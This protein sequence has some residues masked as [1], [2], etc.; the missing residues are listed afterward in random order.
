MTAPRRLADPPPGRQEIHA[1]VTEQLGDLIAVPPSGAISADPAT[2]MAGGQQAADAALRA[3][4]VRGYA[5]LRNNVWPP[6]SRGSSR[7]SPYIRHGLLTLREVWNHVADGPQADVTKFRDELLWQ[8]YA[9]HL[10]A[11]MGTASRKSYRFAVEERTAQDLAEQPGGPWA[12]SALC[13]QS[14]WT[15]LVADGWLTNQTRMWLASHWSVRE[16]LGW[17]DGEDLMYRHLLDG[18]RAARGGLAA[19]VAVVGTAPSGI[20]RLLHGGGQ[21]RRIA[22]GQRQRAAISSVSIGRFINRSER[23]DLQSRYHRGVAVGGSGDHHA[24]DAKPGLVRQSRCLRCHRAPQVDSRQAGICGT[25]DDRDPAEV[26]TAA[27]DEGEPDDGDE[28][29]V[30]SSGR[31]LRGPNHDVGHRYLGSATLG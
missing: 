12:S 23:C 28:P 4:N 3:Y 31:V 18:S 20:D 24:L 1:W 29:L 13:L 9:R 6:P 17:R 14:S 27:F 11:R 8:E 10:Y 16:G 21:G 22:A 26:D 15:E 19:P 7:L 5:R 25:A 30:Q 2:P